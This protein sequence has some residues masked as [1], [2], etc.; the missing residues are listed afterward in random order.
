M[1]APLSDVTKFHFICLF[2]V[3]QERM[4]AKAIE[5]AAERAKLAESEILRMEVRAALSSF[6]DLVLLQRQKLLTRL[7][8]PMH[9][10]TS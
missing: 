1:I 6:T 2:A 9:L 10:P 3:L 7:I 4:D 8:M 5:Y